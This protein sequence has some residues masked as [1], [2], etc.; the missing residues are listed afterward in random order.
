MPEV[1]HVT[2]AITEATANTYKK[3][4]FT[5]TG[6]KPGAT[7]IKI[8]CE[9]SVPDANS[10][11]VATALS[12]GDKESRTGMSVLSTSKDVVFKNISNKG[13]AG[14]S[15]NS[16]LKTENFLPGEVALPSDEMTIEICGYSL[17]NPGSAY[18][19]VTFVNK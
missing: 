15:I 8:S 3:S 4:K 5:L 2:A 9:T 7:L 10:S 14:E 13:A 16:I 19:K 1:R 11:R 17:T 12:L 18:Y 6:W